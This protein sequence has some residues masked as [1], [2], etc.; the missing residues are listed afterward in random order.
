VTNEESGDGDGLF[1]LPGGKIVPKKI[2]EKSMKFSENLHSYLD[3]FSSEDNTE[4]LPQSV[5]HF[6]EE[7]INK[8]LEKETN[9]EKLKIKKALMDWFI[10]WEE[11]DT[12]VDDLKNQSVLSWGEYIDFELDGYESEPILEGGYSK[13]V[14]FLVKSLE[15]KTR[16]H[17]NQKVSK[18]KWNDELASVITE[19]DDIF[20]ADFVIIAVSL[21]VLKE[22]HNRL[23]EPNL[24][25][26]KIEI[27]EKMGFGVMNKIFL[28]FDDIFW[29]TDNP[30][31]QLVMTDLKEGEDDLSQTWQNH[32]AGFDGVS[33]Q[34]KV[35]CGWICGKPASFIETLPEED[36][37]QTLWSLLKHYVGATVP[38]PTFCRVSQWGTNANFRGSYSYRPPVC[39]ETS[40]GPWTLA[41]PVLNKEGRTRLFFAGE[42]SDTEHY[43][44]VTGAMTAGCREGARVV[45]IMKGAEVG[46]GRE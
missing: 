19:N 6:L 23:F 28:G 3:K 20:H 30:G 25:H 5:G 13:L 4:P 35:L 11:V 29:D 17:L 38:C 22:T 18:I 37:K 39:D 41:T 12:A 15:G 2:L 46:A 33:G 10:K 44:T 42:A 7:R 21:G 16:F 26:H 14:Q 27:I 8:F 1:Y 43:G 31:I 34:P 32:I 40:I 36:V 24:P 9:V 45:Q